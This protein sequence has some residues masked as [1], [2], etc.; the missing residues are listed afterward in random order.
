M[1]RAPALPLARALPGLS[2]ACE[3]HNQAFDYFEGV[4]R[5]ILYDNPKINTVS[6]SES[7]KNGDLWI[8]D[9]VPK[10]F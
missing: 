3:G 7:N 10:A 6:S 9:S 2:R 5:S 8:I 4:P 1:L